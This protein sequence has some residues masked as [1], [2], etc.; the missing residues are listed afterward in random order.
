[1]EMRPE[2]LNKAVGDSFWAVSVRK[3][4]GEL[5]GERCLQPHTCTVWFQKNEVDSHYLGTES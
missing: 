4:G 2:G 5:A 1:M 3:N